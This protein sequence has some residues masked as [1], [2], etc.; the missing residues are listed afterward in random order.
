MR[1]IA[2]ILVMGAVTGCIGGSGPWNPPAPDCTEGEIRTVTC[3]DGVTTYESE[4]CLEGRWEH[5]MY[6]RDP[7]SPMAESRGAQ[8]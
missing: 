2:F 8:D 1:W 4:R 5:V 7:C 6:F 3:P